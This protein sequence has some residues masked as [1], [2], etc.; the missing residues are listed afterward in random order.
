MIHFLIT[1]TILSSTPKIEVDWV[2]YNGTIYTV[3]ASFSSVQAMAINDGKILATGNSESILERYTSEKVT[4]LE[5]KAVYPGFIDAHCHFLYYGVEKSFAML[6]GTK[7]FEEVIDLVKK[8]DPAKTGGWII[9]RGW[10][11]NDWGVKEF[12][13]CRILDELFP[14]T[15]VFLTRIDGH[16]GLANSK[17]LE[18]AGI[19]AATKIDGG[20]ITVSGEKCTGLLIDNAMTPVQD[21]L[22]IKEKEFQKNALLLAQKDAVKVGLTGVH[23]A[24]VEPWQIELIDEMQKKEKLKMRIYA[25]VS[26]SDSNYQYFFDKGKIKTERLNVRSFKCYADG[27]LGSR[28]AALLEDYSDEPGNKGLLFSTFDSLQGIARRIYGLGFQMCTHAIGDAANRQALDI[29]GGILFKQN[30][31]RWRIEHCQVVNPNDFV[32]FWKYSVIASVQPTHATSDMYWADERLGGTRVKTAYAY[33]DLLRRNNFLAIGSDFPVESVNPLY[34]FYASVARKDLQGFPPEGFQKENALTREEA[35]RGMTIWAAF[36]AFEENE[37]GSLEK[38]KFADFV[39][40]D[41]DIMHIKA[42]RI[43]ETKVLMTVINGE[44]VFQEL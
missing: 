37:K 8:H 20:V 43:P 33:K 23:D 19:N 9:G 18:L 21:I 41:D 7:S 26:W 29:Y 31:Y 36:A 32:K 42:E 17:A 10:D 2:L 38:G 14:E 1:L 22:P 34:G 44:V 16:A 3:D 15:P 6:D 40:L 24:G 5:G 4:D 35:L 27:A 12:P 39:I 13:D 25:M 11:Q 28:G 30:D